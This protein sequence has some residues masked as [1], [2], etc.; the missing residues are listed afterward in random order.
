VVL[1]ALKSSVPASTSLKV[2]PRRV[3]LPTDYH[4]YEV[5]KKAAN[6][7]PFKKIYS[8]II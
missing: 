2:L 6:Y 1:L 3:S 7:A 8:L 5:I 4:L